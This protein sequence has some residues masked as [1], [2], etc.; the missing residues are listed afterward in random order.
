MTCLA[1][2]TLHVVSYKAA[3]VGCGIA[4]P[5]CPPLQ[6]SKTMTLTT[7]MCIVCRPA[8]I[9]CAQQ[10]NK[11]CSDAYQACSGEISCPSIGLSIL[12]A[13]CQQLLL[14]LHRLCL[15]PDNLRETTTIDCL[16]VPTVSIMAVGHMQRPEAARL[17][18]AR[19]CL[20]LPGSTARVCHT[21]WLCL[22]ILSR[23]G[24]LFS[25][26]LPCNH[27]GRRC[28]QGQRHAQAQ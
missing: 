18:P 2:P 28:Q 4:V 6:F 24:S 9:E 25:C 26:S 5:Y 8:T 3:P 20:P 12:R 15:P 11:Q 7:C 19:E 22:L 17:S 27:Q 23:S 14:Q 10:L 1:V 13:C 21:V 16:A